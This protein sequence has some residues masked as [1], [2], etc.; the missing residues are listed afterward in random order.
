MVST[1]TQK[2]WEVKTTDDH[3]VAPVLINYVEITLSISDSHLSPNHFNF[4]FI[5]LTFMLLGKYL[6]SIKKRG[7]AY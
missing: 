6:D 3:F 2:V 5:S 4:R 7:L 1:L